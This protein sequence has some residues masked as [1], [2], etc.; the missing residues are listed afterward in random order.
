MY[1]EMHH[2]SLEGEDLTISGLG[3]VWPPVEVWLLCGLGGML[4]S[5]LLSLGQ[6]LFLP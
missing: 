5:L 3:R 6:S 4:S 1:K 2:V